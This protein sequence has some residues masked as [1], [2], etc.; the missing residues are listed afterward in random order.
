MN[1]FKLN[2]ME[3]L[4]QRKGFIDRT[5]DLIDRRNMLGERWAL[6]AKN[7]SMEA[8]CKELEQIKSTRTYKVLRAI[9]LLK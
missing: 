3:Y 6:Q 5:H 4:T 1:I 7:T 8:R 2:I 9:G